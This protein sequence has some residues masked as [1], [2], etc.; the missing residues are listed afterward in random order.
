MN[1]TQAGFLTVCAIAST[2]LQQ[3]SNWGFTNRKTTFTIKYLQFLHQTGNKLKHNQFDTHLTKGTTS[4][5]QNTRQTRIK[6]GYWWLTSVSPGSHPQLQAPTCSCSPPK[7]MFIVPS[8][9]L[10]KLNTMFLLP[11]SWGPCLE[12][13]PS[14]PCSCGP[15]LE[16]VPSELS[17]FLKTMN[18]NNKFLWKSMM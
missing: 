18:V 2:G 5:Q 10:L 11:C 17:L 8:A 15:G 14:E 4:L 7:I 1:V 16:V 12:V 13:V 6:P 3:S 9:S